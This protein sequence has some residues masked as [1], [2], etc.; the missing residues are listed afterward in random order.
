M[1]K[2]LEYNLIDENWIPVYYLDG[3]FKE[4]SLQ[5]VF[6]DAHLIETICAENAI[7]NMA[8]SRFLLVFM[9]RFNAITNRKEWKDVFNKGQID[10]LAIDKYLNK[11]RN[12]FDL[13][14]EDKPFYQNKDIKKDKETSITCLEYKGETSASI[15]DHRIKN[16]NYFMPVNIAARNLITVQTISHSSG[17]NIF[18][19]I[20]SG[21]SVLIKGKNL[22]ETLCFN[23]VPYSNDN[24]I[25]RNSDLDM[26]YWEREGSDSNPELKGYLDYLTYQHKDMLLIPIIE[27]ERIVFKRLYSQV[28]KAEYGY[29]KSTIDDPFMPIE[30]GINS[31]T[32]KEF[33]K[34]LKLD[35]NKSIWMG[36]KAIFAEQTRPTCL[37]E[38]ENMRYV[39]D[40]IFIDLE[41]LNLNTNNAIIKSFSHHKIPFNLKLLYKENEEI[42]ISLG[43]I[44]Q[45]I[46]KIDKIFSK[47]DFDFPLC[48][49]AIEMDFWFYIDD[50]MKNIFYQL[51]QTN[52]DDYDNFVKQ[53]IRE[54]KR[55]AISICDNSIRRIR[56]LN[57]KEYINK[58]SLLKD[59]LK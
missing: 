44:T 33:K 43:Y 17:G 1:K 12:C 24:L 37:V 30:K 23:S 11:F 28:K 53:S 6:K 58:N 41:I 14:S 46:E 55:Q 27:N 20:Y 4:I 18:S 32:R 8:L 16:S 48:K 13:C 56:V 3:T 59:I 34:Y 29:D 54:I 21:L 25:I 42:I 40:R 19:V 35:E 51:N 26:P 57:K 49:K 31:K 50:F 10:S 47:K 38:R 36:S 9:Y 5:R 2:E 7:V 52:I 45:A 15:F 39:D 22:F